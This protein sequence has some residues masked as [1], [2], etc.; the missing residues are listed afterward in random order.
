MRVF[1]HYNS[2]DGSETDGIRWRTILQFGN[3][4]QIK[5]SVVMKN[6]G[7]AKFKHSDKRAV[8]SHELLEA[9]QIFDDGRLKDEWFEF[10]PDPTMQCIEE[11]FTAY[12]AYRNERLEGVVQLFNLFYLREA[13][14]GKALKKEELNSFDTRKMVDYDIAHLHAP[15]YLGFGGLAWHKD[16]KETAERYFN[17]SKQLE[18]SYLA[19]K[20]RQERYLHPLYLMRFGRNKA[21]CIMKRFQFIQNT[22][23]PKISEDE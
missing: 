13:D 15:V 12:Y 3:S 7:A 17:A 8:S 21:N 10:S 19:D 4:W 1:T 18:M 9:L 20:F 2:I 14:L 6:P 22:Q 23:Q 5:G 11:L 16:Y